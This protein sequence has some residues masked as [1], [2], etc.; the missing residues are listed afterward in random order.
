VGINEKKHMIKM[1]TEKGDVVVYTD[2]LRDAIDTIM[3]IPPMPPPKAIY[4]EE[5]VMR[6]AQAMAQ[7]WISQQQAAQQQ[8]F[9]QRSRTQGVQAQQA[10][11]VPQGMQQQI[12]SSFLDI[13]PDKMTREIW[14]S[15]TKVQQEEYAKR[16]MK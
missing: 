8:A 11:P 9:E 5:E 14:G 4:T 12:P 15:L 13:T 2:D 7:Q 3:T 6:R 1:S 16:Y 10:G